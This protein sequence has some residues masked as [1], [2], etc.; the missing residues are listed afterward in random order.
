MK[1]KPHTFI[2]V[3]GYIVLTK[4][5]GTSLCL[6]YCFLKNLAV[7]KGK[8]HC[9]V[10]CLCLWCVDLIVTLTILVNWQTHNAWKHLTWLELIKTRMLE[11]LLEDS[12]SNLGVFF[13]PHMDM[14]NMLTLSTDLPTSS[15]EILV[16]YVKS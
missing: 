5:T 6:S 9:I 8:G 14:G 10:C 2:N 16:A 4:K 13:T 3:C 12:I 15:Y 11:T 7:Y 1:H